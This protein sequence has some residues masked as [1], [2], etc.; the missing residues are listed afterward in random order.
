MLERAQRLPICGAH[1]G[2]KRPGGRLSSGAGWARLRCALPP[3]LRHTKRRGRHRVLPH[4]HNTDGCPFGPPCV[5]AHQ[6]GH[7]LVHGG[8]RLTGSQGNKTGCVNNPG[9]GGVLRER[10]IQSWKIAGKIAGKLWCRDQTSRSLKE[11]HYCTGDTRG[12]NKHARWTSKKQV[13]KTCGKLRKIEK[14][15]EKLRALIPSPPRRKNSFG[16]WPRALLVNRGE[17]VRP[18]EHSN[19]PTAVP[20]HANSA[21]PPQELSCMPPPPLVRATVNDQKLTERRLAAWTRVLLTRY[22]VHGT[23]GWTWCTILKTEGQNMPQRP[24]CPNQLP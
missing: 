21:L 14:N 4:L 10:Q 2:L 20:R 17:G 22:T 24:S 6:S 15:C 23:C 11:Q 1:T 5:I 18:S 8:S 12:T 16:S 7:S 3:P 13:G 19:S 9:G